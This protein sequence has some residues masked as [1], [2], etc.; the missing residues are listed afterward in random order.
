MSGPASSGERALGLTVPLFA[1]VSSYYSQG[2]YA[3]APR[4]VLLDEVF[5]GIDAALRAAGVCGSLWS[6]WMVRSRTVQPCAPQPEWHGLPWPM[7][8]IATYG[9]KPG[10]NAL[11]PAPC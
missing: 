10:C 4:L 1:A 11:P 2:A 6:T 9:C 8:Q 3:Q 5:A 7:D